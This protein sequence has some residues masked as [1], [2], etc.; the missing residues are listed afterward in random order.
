MSQRR[1]GRIVLALFNAVLCTFFMPRSISSQ[2]CC[3]VPATE[4][5]LDSGTNWLTLQEQFKQTLSDSAGDV[6]DAHMVQELTT[7]PGQ[8]TCYWSGW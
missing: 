2:S 1:L 6:F 3:A 7:R 4:D 8:D 5:S